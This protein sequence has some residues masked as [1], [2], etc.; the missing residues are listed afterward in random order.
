M[1]S[2]LSLVLVVLVSF[3]VFAQ[4]SAPAN[5][6]VVEDLIREA[7][8]NNPAISALLERLQSLE[9]RIPQ[10]G[11]RPDPVISISAMNYPVALNPLNIDR[12]PMTQTQFSVAQTFLASGT[13]QWRE[14]I[15]R[16]DLKLANNSVDEQK[17]QIATMVKKA[18]VQLAYSQRIL[19]IIERNKTLFDQIVESA[20]AKYTVG[21]NHLQDVLKAKVETSKINLLIIEQKRAMETQRARINILLNRDP[22]AALGRT[23]S[24]V[25]TYFD[26]SLADWLQTALLGNPRYRTVQTAV[27]KSEAEIE[28]STRRLNPDYTVRF[29]YGYR[30]DK[31][32]FWTAGV[33]FNLPFWRGSKQREKIA[34]SEAGKRLNLTMLS[35]RQNELSLAIKEQLIQIDNARDQLSVYEETLIP[36]TRLAM[37]SSL[38]AYQVDKTDILNVLDTQK[39]LFTMDLAVA[40]LFLQHELAVV[41]LEA[42]AGTL[43]FR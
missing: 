24:I 29:A 37:E 4:E 40:R 42:T 10:A 26:K 1:K 35:V 43:P 14:E 3:P 19:E 36:Q 12:E 27:E 23:P 7:I 25:L 6:L 20:Q 11:A 28:L 30:Y 22:E 13:L 15:A 34:E 16:L 2:N 38:S 5:E 8:A 9:H 17:L 18:V 33:S 21:K 31:V 32:D 41:T 39:T